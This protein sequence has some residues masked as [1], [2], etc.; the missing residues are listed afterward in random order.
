MNSLPPVDWKVGAGRSNPPNSDRM[1]HPYVYQS[2]LSRQTEVLVND[3]SVAY[4]V[5]AG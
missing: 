3:A 5:A 2:S 1:F 4:E